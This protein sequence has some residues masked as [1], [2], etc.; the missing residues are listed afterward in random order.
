MTRNGRCWWSIKNASFPFNPRAHLTPVAYCPVRRTQDVSVAG[1]EGLGLQQMLA[2]F[3]RQ[4]LLI[5]A[6]GLDAQHRSCLLS[7]GS[8]SR[9]T[10]F[11][12]PGP[13]PEDTHG[14]V[15]EDDQKLPIHTHMCVCVCFFQ[16]NH[17]KEKPG[18]KVQVTEPGCK[19]NFREV[20]R[21]KRLKWPLSGVRYT[22]IAK[23]VFVNRLLH[24]GSHWPR[25]TYVLY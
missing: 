19:A 8:A 14:P 12:L 16:F 15:R 1:N 9:R 11:P 13:P 4:S 25:K 21:E 20:S 23:N 24:P 22:L 17:W 18:T 3:S 10:R 2:V 5:G 6:H 7:M